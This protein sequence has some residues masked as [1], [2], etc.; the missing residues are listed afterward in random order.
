MNTFI[1]TVW[2]LDDDNVKH[3]IVIK[4]RSELLFLKERF[5]KVGMLTA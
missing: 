5:E 1:R 4:S 2:Y 3:I